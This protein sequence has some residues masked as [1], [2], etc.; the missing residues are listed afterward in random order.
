[1]FISGQSQQLE[2][3]PGETSVHVDL[4]LR[5]EV[6]HHRMLLAMLQHLI[7]RINWP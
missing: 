5:L 4:S 2:G 6:R 7:M 3:M 1:M